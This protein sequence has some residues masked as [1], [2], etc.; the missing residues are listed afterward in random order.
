MPRVLDPHTG[1]VKIPKIVQ[2]RTRQG[3]EKYAK[4]KYGRR[5]TRI[6]RVI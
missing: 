2:E 1:G 6:V 3:I 4:K 5:F